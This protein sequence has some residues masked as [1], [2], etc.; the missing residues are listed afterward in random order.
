MIFVPELDMLE[1][2]SCD[3]IFKGLRVI[4][5]IKISVIISSLTWITHQYNAA[6]RS[7]MQ[8]W[9]NGFAYG[10]VYACGSTFIII[11]KIEYFERNKW[12][13]LFRYVV[14]I[15]TTVV[16]DYNIGAPVTGKNCQQHSLNQWWDRIRLF[17][18]LCAYS[19]SFD[20]GFEKSSVQIKMYRKYEIN[21]NDV[22][23]MI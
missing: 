1:Y 17:M 4:F 20:F 18:S 22:F 14:Y 8:I 19:M 16:C 12:T 7:K 15:T 2:Q 5:E 13:G 6:F 3:W 21:S 11:S 10:M 9:S 23:L